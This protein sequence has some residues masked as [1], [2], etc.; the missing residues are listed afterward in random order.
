MTFGDKKNSYSTTNNKFHENSFNI[1][2][3]TFE[4][5]KDNTFYKNQKK[6]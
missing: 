2:T 5:Y 4:E 3:D 6:Q 1:Q